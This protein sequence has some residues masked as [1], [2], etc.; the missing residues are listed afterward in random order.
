M[1]QGQ[2]AGQADTA[3]APAQP[4]DDAGRFASLETKYQHPIDEQQSLHD[5]MLRY[6]QQ[7]GTDGEWTGDPS[8]PQEQ[9][10]PA[11]ADAPPAEQPEGEQAAAEQG[12][13]ESFEIDPEAPLFEA[14]IGEE[15]VKLSLKELQSGYLRQA[16]YTRKTQ[17]LAKA[18]EEI[19]THVQTAAQ[20][21]QQYYL[22][23]LQ[24][25]QASMIQ[26][27]APELQNVDWNRLANEDPAE[28]VRLSAKAQ[29]V[30]GTLERTQQQ[31]V[32]AAQQQKAQADAQLAKNIEESIQVLQRDLP[33]WG[34]ELYQ[35]ILKES[36]SNYGF[37]QEELNN[38]WDARVIKAIHDANA[39]R[40]LKAAQ[41]EV[42]KKVV[43]VPKVIKPGNRAAPSN[44]AKAE[45]SKALDRLQKTGNWKDAAQALLLRGSTK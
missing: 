19:Q 36:A 22:Q 21:A 39:Y 32:A 17:E 3:Q 24:A 11:D 26:M 18:R 13:E 16:D 14:K 2:V 27:A 42:Q 37:S 6:V 1:E 38:I 4:R 25:I 40:K 41:P 23:Q 45:A 8:Q 31:L 9:A 15:N 5:R 20:Q 10:A 33:G 29:T 34:N 30:R 44:P 43:A 12:S 35:T 7:D 28:F